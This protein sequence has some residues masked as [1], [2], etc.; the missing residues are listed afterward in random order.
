HVVVDLQGRVALCVD[1]GG[2]FTD[3]VIVDLDIGEVVRRHKVLTNAQFPARGVLRGWRDLTKNG[4]IAA[5]DVGLAVHSTTLVTNSIIERKG[6]RTALLTTK[7]FRDI[8]ELGREQLYDIYALFAPPP[9]PLVPR[10][11]SRHVDARVT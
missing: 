2:T 5:H 10:P 1:V 7:G 4:E 6:A 8:L 3:F 9:A 11:P